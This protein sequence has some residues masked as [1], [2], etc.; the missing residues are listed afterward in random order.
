LVK[1]DIF[2]AIWQ[3]FHKFIGRLN[4]QNFIQIYSDST[5]L[6]HDVFY[7][8]QCIRQ[9]DVS[10]NYTLSDSQELWLF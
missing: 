3:S 9:N 6:L 8:T 10:Y 7:R 1:N 2:N 5:F 4:I